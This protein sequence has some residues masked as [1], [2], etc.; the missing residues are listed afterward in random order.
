LLLLLPSAPFSFLVW[1]ISGGF[2]A[3]SILKPPTRKS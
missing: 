2:A 3:G 1:G